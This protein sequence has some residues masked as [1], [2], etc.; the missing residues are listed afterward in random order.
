MNSTWMNSSTQWHVELYTKKVWVFSKIVSSWQRSNF[1]LRCMISPIVCFLALV[2]LSCSCKLFIFI[3][4]CRGFYLA[5]AVSNLCWCWFF[6][7]SNGHD[8]QHHVVIRLSWPHGDYVYSYKCFRDAMDWV[9][10]RHSCWFQSTGSIFKMRNNVFVLWEVLAADVCIAC[11][12]S[13]WRVVYFTNSFFPLFNYF[14]V[15]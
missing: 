8:W 12:L 2:L 9:T 14:L 3:F 1:C 11:C 7:R 13:L 5:P 15:I 4:S 6:C 10:Y